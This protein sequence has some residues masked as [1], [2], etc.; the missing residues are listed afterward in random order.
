VESSVAELTEQQLQLA[1][2]QEESRVSREAATQEVALIHQEAQHG[3]DEL[4]QSKQQILADITSAELT[5]AALDISIEQSQTRLQT[6]TQQFSEETGEQTPATLARITHLDA[7]VERLKVLQEA[8]EAEMQAAR[9][10]AV[11]MQQE[12]EEARDRALRVSKAASEEV[13]QL[14]QEQQEAEVRWA[15]LYCV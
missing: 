9:S 14:R 2:Q 10:H 12:A 1:T 3:L 11:V 15:L 4:E 13:E 7:E 6:D 5:V 8:A